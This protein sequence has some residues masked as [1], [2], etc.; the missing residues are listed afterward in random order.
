MLLLATLIMAAIPTEAEGAVYEDT[1]RLHIPANSDSDADQ[2]IKL[3]I[4]DR[5]LGKYSDGLSGFSSAKEAAEELQG[6]T[7]EIKQDVDLW[8]LEAGF[9]YGCTV[10]ITEE[11]FDT[12][13]YGDASLPCGNYTALKIVLGEGKGKNWWCVMFPPMCL[14]IATSGG[15]DILTGYN[16]EEYRLIKSGKYSVK[17]KLLEILSECCA[18]VSKNG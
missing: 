3:E 10:T 12:R 1:V 8:L 5:I 6:I 2:K 18:E 16:D 17:F 15:G 14:G 4:R 11:W 7:E 9:D 13:D